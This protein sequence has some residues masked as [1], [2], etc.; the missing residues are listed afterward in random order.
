M[1]RCFKFMIC[2]N[3]PKVYLMSFCVVM[4]NHVDPVYV[5][6][7]SVGTYY[8]IVKNRRSRRRNRLGILEKLPQAGSDDV[9]EFLKSGAF[10]FDP[11]QVAFPAG[12]QQFN[13]ESAVE[14]YYFLLCYVAAGSTFQ[15]TDENMPVASST[16]QMS[17]KGKEP[18]IVPGGYDSLCRV[19]EGK[20]FQ[21]HYHVRIEEQVFPIALVQA[22]FVP[23]KTLIKPFVC[24][25][26][27]LEPAQVYCSNDRAHFC[28]KCDES[29]HMQDRLLQRHKRLSIEHTPYQFGTCAHHPTERWG[30]HQQHGKHYHSAGGL[31]VIILFPMKF[32]LFFSP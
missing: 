14:M 27:E 1:C 28:A 22:Q 9:T 5:L 13:P 31:I 32:F 19:E 6:V 10:L 25:I 18:V 12:R 21:L 26:C 23:V 7:E 15:A 4:M 24:E 3:V 29:F 8:T 11:T 17:K 16:Q 20:N 30:V 2:T